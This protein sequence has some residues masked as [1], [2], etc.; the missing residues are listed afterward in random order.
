M[1]EF[2]LEPGEH[3]VRQTRKHWFIFLLEL[4]PYAILA[5]IPFAI[6]KILILTAFTAP[7]ATYFD[8]HTLLAR[9]ALGM[10]LLIVWTSAWGTFTRYFLN[11]WV[12]TNQRIVD[13]KQR[14]FFKRGVSSL[15]LPR[16]QDVTTDVSGILSS[17]LDIGDIKVQSAAADVEFTM[18]DIPH[19]EQM[20]DI[21]LKYVSTKSQDS[22]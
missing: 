14:G 18:R 4:L 2:E 19:P 10:W 15:L 6:P 9:V 20:R 8:Y 22:V 3:V 1:K 12:L 7:Y 13:I 5:I 11:A 21:V 16:V 17:L